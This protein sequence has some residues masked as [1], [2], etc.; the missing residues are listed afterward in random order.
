[1]LLGLRNTQAKAKVANSLEGRFSMAR[2]DQHRGIDISVEYSAKY[3]DGSSGPSEVQI[4]S[5]TMSA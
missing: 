5:M 3:G 4:F 2:S 1:M